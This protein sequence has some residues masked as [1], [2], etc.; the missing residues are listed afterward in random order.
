MP[1]DAQ[2]GV[3][4]INAA[5]EARASD[6]ASPLIWVFARHQRGMAMR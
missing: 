6:E 1:I 4:F 3:H 5:D 2:G